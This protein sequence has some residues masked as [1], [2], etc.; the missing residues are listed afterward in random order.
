MTVKSCRW[1]TP[2][3]TVP[4]WGMLAKAQ[5]VS[6]RFSGSPPVASF[7]STRVRSSPKAR[8]SDSVVRMRSLDPDH[9][10]SVNTVD[11]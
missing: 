11:V 2:R 6:G 8:M 3:S 7:T 10:D 9:T 4:P 1:L 5:T